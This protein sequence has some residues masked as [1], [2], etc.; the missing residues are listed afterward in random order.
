[1]CRGV[2]LAKIDEAALGQADVQKLLQY[3]YSLA[4]PMTEHART[5]YANE[6]LRKE[7][8]RLLAQKFSQ[9]AFA[10]FTL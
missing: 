7:K 1:M 9:R 3:L 2:L 4:G 5:E 6:Y 8:A 10:K